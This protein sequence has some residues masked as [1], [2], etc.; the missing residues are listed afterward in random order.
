MALEDGGGTAVLCT[1]VTG[2]ARGR[3]TSEEVGSAAAAVGLADLAAGAAMAIVTRA[4][5]APGGV[6]SSS[7]K[8]VIDTPECATP[9]GSMRRGSAVAV[10]TG[11]LRS[12]ELGGGAVDRA[13]LAAAEAFCFL[14][15]SSLEVRSAAS[16]FC[17]GAGAAEVF[18]AAG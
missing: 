9:D 2:E 8:S 16:L 1:T 18:E 17:E 12:A 11:A 6:Y 10:A 3:V 14:A 7:S 15:R 13:C 5:E 4:E